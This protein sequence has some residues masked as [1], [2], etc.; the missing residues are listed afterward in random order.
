M[1]RESNNRL[2]D[3]RAEKKEEK[4]RRLRATPLNGVKI[5]NNSIKEKANE[6]RKD[7]KRG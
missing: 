1:D 5:Q 2:N 7:S 6:E 4:K 3:D